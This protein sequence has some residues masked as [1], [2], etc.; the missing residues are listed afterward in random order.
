MLLP[1]SLLPLSLPS[2][3]HLIGLAVEASASRAADLGFHSR[4][5]LDYSGSSHTSDLRIDTPVVTLLGA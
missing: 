1:P 2:A 5:C 4:L 3:D